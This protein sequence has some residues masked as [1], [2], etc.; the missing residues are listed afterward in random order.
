MLPGD[1][2]LGIG[3]ARGLEAWNRWGQGNGGW[4]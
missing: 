4:E 1:W 2:G 3:G